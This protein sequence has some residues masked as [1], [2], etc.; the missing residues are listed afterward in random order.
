VLAGIREFELVSVN[1]RPRRA[2]RK[3]SG[4][5]SYLL[6]FLLL[7]VDNRNASSDTRRSWPPQMV[8]AG[9]APVVISGGL[10]HSWV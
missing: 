1:H 6:S 2:C 8:L 10:C 5:H 4:E 7:C 3:L 9:D